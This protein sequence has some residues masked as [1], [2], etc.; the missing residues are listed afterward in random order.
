[1]HGKIKSYV[2]SN[3]WSCQ[4]KVFRNTVLTCHLSNANCYE[5][6]VLLH[7]YNHIN[8][9]AVQDYYLIYVYV[10]YV[11]TIKITVYEYLVIERRHFK[12]TQFKHKVNETTK[13]IR[14]CR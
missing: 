6:A 14:L 7:L 2:V 12:N 11:Y 9:L 3:T 8:N 5:T 4:S 1:M 10:G 13:K